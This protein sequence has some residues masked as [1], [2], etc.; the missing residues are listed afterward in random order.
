MADADRTTDA[1][2]LIDGLRTRRS[3]HNF[4]PDA[5]IDDDTLTELIRDA[6]LAPSSYN[7]QPWEFVAVQDDDRL[8][9]LAEIAY[10]QQHIV[11]AGTAILVAGHTDP[12]TADRVFEEWVDAGRFDADTG[13][14]LKSQTVASYESDQAGRDYAI[15]NASLAAQNLLLSAHARG[16]TA[17][18]MSGF[19]F[20]AAAEFAGL[21]AD[22]VPVVLIAVGP[23]GGEEPDRLPRRS[24]DGVLHRESM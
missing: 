16:L 8:A 23:S 11:D 14:E 10:D 24:V 3:G 17:T 1:D 7:L 2:A 18:P 13:A 5:D 6:T 21:P 4:D 22:T 9:E 19:D 12:K 15:R 20:E